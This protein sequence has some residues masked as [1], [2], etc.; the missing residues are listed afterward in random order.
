M[1]AVKRIELRPKRYCADEVILHSEAGIILSKSVEDA[2][3]LPRS[4]GGEL[5]AMS[6]FLEAT[7]L[8][9]AESMH[10]EELEEGVVYSKHGIAVVSKRTFEKLISG[11]HREPLVYV[12]RGGIYVKV[13]GD[14]LRRL[15]EE[16]KLSRGELAEKLGVT[17]R[18]VANYEENSC[19]VTL[20]VAVRLESLLGN[21]VFEKL[22]LK[23][24]SRMFAS[25]RPAGGMNPRDEYLRA[26]LSNLEKHGFKSYAFSKAPI[27]AGL[28]GSFGESK[29]A[30][31]RH[32][33]ET[34]PQELELAAT[35]SDETGT[36][37]I[38]ITD[39]KEDLSM[40]DE[41]LAIPKGEVSNVSRKIISYIRGLG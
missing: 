5:R 14:V 37:L 30:I 18:M 24:I 10:G 36:K 1:S 40:A 7:P 6:D 33:E 3:H 39:S 35:L 9:T 16:R 17:P 19:D 25:S 2:A 32:S 23:A 11:E 31:K 29:A 13:K 22:S 28:K 15:R 34:E 38:V 20:E 21:E 27:D 26:L 41:Y 4:I 8:I 12:H